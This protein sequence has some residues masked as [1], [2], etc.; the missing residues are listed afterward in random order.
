M[1]CNYNR[2]L[3]REREHSTRATLAARQPGEQQHMRAEKK[4]MT[5]TLYKSYAQVPIGTGEQKPPGDGL[6]S[7]QSRG[8]NV[9]HEGLAKDPVRLHSGSHS[10]GNGVQMSCR[11]ARAP[12]VWGAVET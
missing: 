7:R 2:F 1:R 10:S 9:L 3:N 12:C 8:T 4:I 5:G 6:K 11:V